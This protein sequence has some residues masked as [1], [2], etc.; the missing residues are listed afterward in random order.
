MGHRNFL[1]VLST[2]V[3]SFLSSSAYAQFKG[4]VP[5]DFRLLVFFINQFLLAPSIPLGPFRLFSKTRG[6][7]CSSRCTTGV[8][9][10]IGKFA[11]GVFDTGGHFVPGIIDGLTPTANLPPVST[12]LAKLVGKFAVGVVDTGGEP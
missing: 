4:T 3:H 1:S 5:R 6:D 7:I 12:T 11:I 8:V 2:R 9:D 10:T